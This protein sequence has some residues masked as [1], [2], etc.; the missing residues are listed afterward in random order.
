MAYIG[1]D[2]QT[3]RQITKRVIRLLRPLPKFDLG[4]PWQCFCGDTTWVKYRSHYYCPHCGRRFND[5][6]LDETF[7]GTRKETF[8]Q[9]F[10]RC[11]SA[12]G[13]ASERSD[14]G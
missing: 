13:S 2:N 4:W 9:A 1:G 10:A 8:R 12:A 6:A 14:E 3:M 11:K 7:G 5:R